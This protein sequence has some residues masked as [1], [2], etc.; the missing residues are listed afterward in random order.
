M[1]EVSLLKEGEIPHPTGYRILVEVE[2]DPMIAKV[3]QGDS[4]LVLPDQVVKSEMQGA[5][6]GTIV[7]IGPLAATAPGE[8]RDDWGLKVGNIVIVERYGNYFIQTPEGKAYILLAS[9]QAIHAVI[10]PEETEAKMF[11]KE[12]QEVENVR[13]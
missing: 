4:G 11:K 1:M 12:T 7:E 13:S 3:M 5:Q 2:P 9:E 10:Y 6:R 8:T